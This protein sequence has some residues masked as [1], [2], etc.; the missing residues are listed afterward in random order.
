MQILSY[1]TTA[2]IRVFHFTC[3][4]PLWVV[5]K[6][7][8]YILL[9]WIWFLTSNID[10]PLLCTWLCQA[11]GGVSCQCTQVTCQLTRFLLC[12]YHC[13]AEECKP[14]WFIHIGEFCNWMDI[15]HCLERGVIYSFSSE[16]TIVLITW[17]ITLSQQQKKKLKF[18]YSG[19][20]P[21]PPSAAIGCWSWK[22]FILF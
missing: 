18:S 4:Y 11:R 2:F 1:F 10:C 13:S 5:Y 20:L 14:Q 12:F 16:L 9:A 19:L 3:I 8:I 21:L 22:S 17:I 15:D 7:P 6:F